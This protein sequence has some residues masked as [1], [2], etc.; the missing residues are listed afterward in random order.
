ME[1]NNYIQQEVRLTELKRYEDGMVRYV[2]AFPDYYIYGLPNIGMQVIYRECALH[3]GVVADRYYLPD[4]DCKDKDITWE[5]KT[6][7]K[8]CDFLSFTISY[9]GSYVNI[10][11]ELELCNIPLHACDRNDDYPIIIGGGPIVMYNCRPL[12]KFFDVF[13]LGEGEQVIHDILD[14]Y[15]KNKNMGKTVVLKELSKIRGVYVPS[16]KEIKKV[17]QVPVVPIDKYPAHSEFMTKQCVYGEKTFTIEIRRGCNQKCRFCYMGTRLRP[18]RMIS[19]DTFKKLVDEGL[20]H[21]KIIKC[22]YEG[23]DTDVI[24]RYLEYIVKNGGLVRIG[25][26]RLEKVSN[27]I[28]EMIAES[29]QRKLVIAPETSERLRR[30]IGK[31]A[32]KND[33]VIELVKKA[34]NNGIQDIGL[35]F[36]IG[37]P[38]ETNA[39]LDEIADLILKV[40]K[41][42]NENGDINGC[43]EIGINPLFPKPMT[44][45]QFSKANSIEEINN[46]FS[47]LKSRLS[48]NCS[49]V[50]S[51]DVVDEKVE[52]RVIDEKDES[53]IKIETTVGSDIVFTQP[54]LSRGGEEI[55]DVLEYVY[56]NGDTYENWKKALDLY[57]IDTSDYFKQLNTNDEFVWDFQKCYASKNHLIREYMLSKESQSSS[58]CSAKCE[59][60]ADKC[61]L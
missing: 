54:I 53:I 41:I 52:R 59:I 26:Q 17:Y 39:D 28:V 55:G 12:D 36:I 16:I 13:V 32:I 19:E 31:E 1:I 43:L 23:V 29:G 46:K 49:L 3:P 5:R 42:M 58:Q 27:R 44:A 20:K 9:E 35:Y 60:C 47:Y 4:E 37:I 18:A 38:S 24:Q 7:I 51:N 57:N 61:S 22:F 8:E 56:R 33:K 2:C 45:L 50:I 34:M 40:R 6:K 30:V 48:D 25:S 10:L 14:V 21:C 11:K 15:I